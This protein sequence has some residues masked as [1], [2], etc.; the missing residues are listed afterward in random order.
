MDLNVAAV[1]PLC[2][3]LHAKCAPCRSLDAVAMQLKAL[4]QDASF[5]LVRQVENFDRDLLASVQRLPG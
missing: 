1:S 5:K 2:H 3:K 4:A